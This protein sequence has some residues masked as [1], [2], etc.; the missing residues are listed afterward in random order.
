M[1]MVAPTIITKN[2]QKHKC[3]SMGRWINKLFIEYNSIKKE[4][5]ADMCNVMDEMR[6]LHTVW[7][8]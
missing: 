1:F 5:T 8:Y 4:G 6:T 3:P 2:W 7:F